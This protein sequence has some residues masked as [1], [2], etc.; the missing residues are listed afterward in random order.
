LEE[1]L[2]TRT[3]HA[4]PWRV[5]KAWI[6]EQMMA[7]WWGPQGF[8]KEVC[9][10]DV[11]RGGE[12]YIVLKNKQGHA[13]VVK[14]NFELIDEPEQLVFTST[15]CFD[16]HGKPRLKILNTVVFLSERYYTKLT[17]QAVVMKSTPETASSVITMMACWSESLDRLDKLLLKQSFTYTNYQNTSDDND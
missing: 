8:Y 10:L 3:I 9:K 13:F 6:S 16:E 5:F 14:G 4:R 11:T 17:L 7:Q 2:I 1:L 12:L 15:A